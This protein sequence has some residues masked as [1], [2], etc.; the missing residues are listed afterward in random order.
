LNP[1]GRG[2]RDRRV[3][4]PVP[5]GVFSS[6]FVDRSLLRRSWISY[7]LYPVS[8]AFSG[9][10][11]LRRFF[12]RHF[13]PEPFPKSVK[14]I[15][16]GNLTA[17]GSGKTPFVIYLAGEL[18][19]RNLSC[20]VLLRGYRGEFEHSGR[21]VA[22]RDG[23]RQELDRAGDE[24]Q[25]IAHSLPGVPV[26]VGRNR[27]EG[28]E[29][30]L[31]EFPDLA[32]VLLDDGF[33][34]LAIRPDFR[35]VVFNTTVGAGNGFTLPAGILREPLSALRDVDAVV[36]N[37]PEDPELTTSLHYRGPVIRGGMKLRRIRDLGGETVDPATLV[38]G[39][40]LLTGIG[41]PAAF[42]RS[43]REAGIPVVGMQAMPDHYDFA[44]SSL[45]SDL[46]RR[47]DRGEFSAVL[48]T[49]KDAVKIARPPVS[50]LVAESG[51]E[52]VSGSD[53]VALVTS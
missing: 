6:K 8:L 51:F 5:S 10:T 34:H 25:L 44:D 21:L 52:P 11:T 14:V 23:F 20:A 18:R 1:A 12:Y 48:V 32:Y 49:E 33:Q 27:R 53:P 29:R 15:V 45:W 7:L 3:V 40:L 30:L 43:M 50:L 24:A 4:A 16:V 41:T 17:G 19:R 31:R 42:E 28:V 22:D 26:A 9:V 36:L 38:P 35:F 2:T 46:V 37:G 47:Q 13:P 39:V